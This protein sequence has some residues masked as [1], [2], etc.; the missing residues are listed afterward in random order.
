MPQEITVDPYYDAEEAVVVSF[1]PK[2]E[3]KE[4]LELQLQD[5][6]NQITY[7]QSEATKLQ[8]KLDLFP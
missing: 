8:T 7:L 1:E 3:T 2:K 4:R 5:I 6:L